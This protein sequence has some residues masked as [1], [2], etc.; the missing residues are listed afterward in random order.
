MPSTQGPG[1]L[2]GRLSQRP[3]GFGSGEAGG[4]KAEQAW[5]KCGLCQAL[6]VDGRRGG[7]LRASVSFPVMRDCKI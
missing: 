5:F 3:P 6:L 2:T 4:S 1:R 7:G